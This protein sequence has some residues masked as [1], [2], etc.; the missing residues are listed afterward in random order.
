M[1]K[2]R[3]AFVAATILATL[4][5]S[6]SLYG[7]ISWPLDFRVFWNAATQPLGDIYQPG[8]MPFAYPPTALFLFKPL[9]LLPRLPA[10]LA[11]TAVSVVLFAVAVTGLGGWKLAIA[12]LITPASIRGLMLGQSA[13]LLGAGLLAAVQ[14]PS[15]AMGIV[16]GLI[17]AV[18]PQLVL[19]AP[20]AFILRRDWKALCGMFGAGSG[21]VMASTL[22]FDPTLWTDWMRSLPAFHNT[23]MN[24]TTLGYLITPAGKVEALGYSPLPVLVLAFAL[25]A[26]AV[27]VTARKVEREMLVGL[28]VLSSLVASPYGHVHDTVAVIP[29]CIVLLFRGYWFIAVP[30]ALILT[31][32]LALLPVGLVLLVAALI[33]ANH[34]PIASLDL[35]RMPLKREA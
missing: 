25:G 17:G 23:V 8:K 7:W 5:S 1:S 28:I 34:R 32:S 21:L 24:G 29:A 20:L 19:F 15:L 16:F 13:M 27:I 12:S 11:W 33:A 22:I 31:G 6:L 10:Y 26:W 4:Y 18:K 2:I 3:L 35:K 30:A 14:L 9:E